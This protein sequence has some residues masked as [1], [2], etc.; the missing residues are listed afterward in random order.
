[1]GKS[2]GG[3]SGRAGVEAEGSDPFAKEIPPRV[4]TVEGILV[5]RTAALFAGRRQN[6]NL[7]RSAVLTGILPRVASRR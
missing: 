1:M 5:V 4:V 6:E 7:D 2:A 3:V